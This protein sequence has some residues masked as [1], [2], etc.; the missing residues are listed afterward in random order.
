MI[1]NP[2]QLNKKISIYRIADTDDDWNSKSDIC[3]YNKISAYIAPIKGAE[4]LENERYYNSNPVR[5]LIRYRTNIDN[6]C[7]IMYHGTRYDITNVVDENMEH[8]NLTIYATEKGRGA[9]E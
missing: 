1:L 7:Y 8:E 4:L 3:L 5:I 9:D 2:G 6:D